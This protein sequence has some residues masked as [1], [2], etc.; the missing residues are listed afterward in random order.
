M[1]INAKIAPKDLKREFARYVV[2]SVAAQW[3]FA[4]YTMV[5]GMFVARGV[6]EMALAAVN[7]S[8]PF[9]NLIF[10]L[11]LVLAVGTST[12][13]SIRFGQQDSEGANR[14][15]TQNLITVGLVS[16]ALIV[17]VLL[18]L[19]TIA[20]FLGAGEH[21]VEYVKTY[22]GTIAAFTPCF[23]LAYYFEILIKA[24][25][26]PKLAT[27][28]VAMGTVLNCLLD[29][30]LVIVFPLGMFGAAFATGISQLAVVI[31]FAI[32][33]FGKKA[34]LRLTRFKPS[35]RLLW[36]TIR[37]GMPSGITDFSA[38]LMIF[39]FNMAILATLGEE[40]LVSYTIVAYV[41]TIVVMSL[42]GVAQ[43][44]QPLASYSYG[45]GNVEQCKKLLRYALVT[46][47]VL[48]VVVLVPTWL[49]AAGIVSIFVSP[50]HTELRRASVE[51][52]RIFSLSFIPV[53]FNVIVSGWLTAVEQEKP[54]ALIAVA[55]GFV[56]ILGALWLLA[57]LFGGAGIWWAALLSEGACA[58]LSAVL[59]LNVLKR[60][61][62]TLKH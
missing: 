52:F 6:G 47:G 15:Y 3:V 57:V 62:I 60:N 30:L 43:G 61:K 44:M 49:G 35:W 11:S 17:A 41:N 26:K 12:I 55:R 50:Q 54:A 28:M 8:L 10:A 48:S 24:D 27:L 19:D 1:K 20:R 58:V 38:G 25:G 45:S 34:K 13:I 18:N 22:V 31:A 42:T 37:L 33:F 46:A 29:W 16:L 7:L 51:V 2:P 4:L 53:G 21:N 39:F 9:V 36:R 5:D 59:L 14:A 40:A 23:M 32:Y 56:F